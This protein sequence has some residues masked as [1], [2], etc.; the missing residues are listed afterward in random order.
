MIGLMILTPQTDGAKCRYEIFFLTWEVNWV[1]FLYVFIFWTVHVGVIL[2]V[3][4]CWKCYVSPIEG[5]VGAINT[6]EEIY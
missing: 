3:M 5:Q 2:V 4:D 6:I 1:E